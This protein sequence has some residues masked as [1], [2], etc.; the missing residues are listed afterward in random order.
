[1]QKLRYSRYFKSAMIILDIIVL[2]L[3]FLYFLSASNEYN[4][5]ALYNEKN[6]FILL[7]LSAFWV[8]ISGKTKLYSIPR[9][10]TFTNYLERFLNHIFLFLVGVIFISRLIEN[11]FIKDNSIKLSLLLFFI[12]LFIKTGVFILLKYIRSKGYNFR[13]IMFLG[14]NSSSKLLKSILEKRN[15]YGF[16]I[17]PYPSEEI[18]IEDLKDFWKSENIHTVFLPSE[19]NWDKETENSIFVEAEKNNVNISLIPNIIKNDFFSYDLNY[20][21]Y[22]P[23]L[24]PV[25]YPLDFFTNYLI[26]RGFD[27]VFS[28]IFVLFIGIWL[29]PIIAF[30][31]K[32]NSKGPVFFL[33][34]RYGYDNRVFNCIKFRT[35]EVNGESSQKTTVKD[36]RRITSV[37]K[38]LR[39]T[40]LDETPQFLNVLLGEMSVVGPRPHMLIIDDF[41]KEKLNR[42][43]IRSLV[44][45]GITGLAQINGHR[46]DKANM[47][48][49]M[50]KRILADS[51]YVKNW[52]FSLDII[53]IFKTLI[54]LVEGDKNAL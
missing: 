20:I 7:S 39:K 38:F 43:K 21:E 13:N 19:N 36:D 50:K 51:F 5:K 12:L 52:S 26:K 37:G 31:I 10:L 34:K 35:M 28:I 8:L 53:I 32:L 47:E 9:I 41:Y 40:S 11:Q 22:L 45:P 1:M 29:Y 23:V 48:I 42:Y 3:V 49:E 30:I 33:Q 4:S 15:D 16:K 25:K 14:E 54:L 44:K 18:K 46:G 2:S 27:I 24:N 6:I 17:F